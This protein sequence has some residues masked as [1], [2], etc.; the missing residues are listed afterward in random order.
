MNDSMFQKLMPPELRPSPSARL[1]DQLKPLNAQIDELI[2]IAGTAGLSLGVYRYGEPN[3]YAN[4]GFRDAAE[5]LP[6]P[7]QT[8]FAGCSL[9]KL[10]TALSMAL[11]V[12]EEDGIEWD[13]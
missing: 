4:F 3:Y 1:V 5:Q 10:F 12:D 8:I 9:T 11:I 6:V 2:N 13:T 7:E